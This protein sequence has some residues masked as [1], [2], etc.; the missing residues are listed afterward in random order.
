[1]MEN[2]SFSLA[3]V[4]KIAVFLINNQ[5]SNRFTSLQVVKKLLIENVKLWAEIEKVSV[6]VAY[7]H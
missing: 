2:D 7:L 5:T 4:E 3:C 1:M 6:R